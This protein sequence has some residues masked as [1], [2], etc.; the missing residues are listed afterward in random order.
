MINKLLADYFGENVPLEERNLNLAMMFFYD[1]FALAL[2]YGLYLRLDLPFYILTIAVVLIVT[3]CYSYILRYE[4]YNTGAFIIG[5]LVTMVELPGAHYFDGRLISAVLVFFTLGFLFCIFNI[6]GKLLLISVV[7]SAISFSMSC[8]GLYMLHYREKP[9]DLARTSILFDVVIPVVICLIY[10]DRALSIKQRIHQREV[11]KAVKEGKK[12][13]DMNR[14]KDVF[15]MNMSHEMRTPMNAIISA[16][17]LIEDKAVNNAVKQHISYIKNA[18]NALVSTIDDLLVFSKVENSRLELINAEYDTGMLFED[19]INM[20]A[21]RLM[22]RDV[23]F[24]VHLDANMPSVLYGD[25]AKLRQVFINVLNNSVKYT[26]EGHIG[27][28][29]SIEKTDNDNEVI[30]RADVEDT[31]IGIKEE[32]I[33]RLFKAFER[34]D[35]REHE[36]MKAEGTGLGLSICKTI[37]DGMGGSINV[38]SRFNRGSVFSFEVKQKMV[39][40]TLM[41]HIDDNSSLNVLVFED[42]E[43]KT[44]MIR[45]ALTESKVKVVC[46]GDSPEFNEL[47]KNGKYT[48]ILISL[49][50]YKEE[51][52]R[53]EGCGI[54]CVIL[55]D[56]NRADE[57]PKNADRIARPVNIL[58]L[59]EY[60]NRTEEVAKKDETRSFMCPNA[61]VMVIDDN[62]TN[63]F[64]AEGLLKRYG[65]NV[66]SVLSGREAL[67]LISDLK[68]DMIFI[69][70]MM[71]GMDGIDTLNAIRDNKQAWCRSVPCVVLTADAADGARQML[72]NAGFDDYISKPIRVDRLAVSIYQLIDPKLIEWQT[73]EKTEAV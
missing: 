7:L 8:I 41:S 69:D 40:S 49:D 17:D 68:F 16:T 55:S 53:L 34:L 67:N 4:K 70:Y 18:C 54:K 26:N 72:L 61:R 71:P 33:P 62:K 44:E 13:E 5:M 28:K 65:M 15:L 32:D 22:D 9:Y 25:S 50:K 45:L 39:D 46:A 47:L 64:V 27:L 30:L 35:D 37:L 24:Y 10:T 57:V 59:S 31:G 20:I 48:H 21:V 52:E 42:D 58:N 63:L 3:I 14:A 36:S 60:F 1:T 2:V 19:I 38:R 29:V 43:M 73:E 51:E 66:I 11:D 12:A 6:N 56:I 23:G